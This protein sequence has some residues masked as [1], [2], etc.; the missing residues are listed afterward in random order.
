MN[1]RAVILLGLLLALL[2]A[3]ILHAEEG[4]APKKPIYYALEPAFVVNLKEGG[5]ARFMQITVQLM[6]RDEKVIQAVEHHQPPIRDAMIM[7]LTHQDSETM[8]SVPGREQVRQQA[9]TE[10]RDVVA[11]V[12]G[13]KQGIEAVYF[14][15]FVIQ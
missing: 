3:P 7:L 4:E 11:E 9:L 2:S 13:I 1:K 6:T 14:T 10:V 15:D 8:R 12:A 5:R